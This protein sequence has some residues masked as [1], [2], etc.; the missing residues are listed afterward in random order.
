MSTQIYTLQV[1]SMKKTEIQRRLQTKYLA[2]RKKV[3]VGASE[4][5]KL[6]EYVNAK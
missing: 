3:G 1:I 6:L 2:L 4:Y 5:G